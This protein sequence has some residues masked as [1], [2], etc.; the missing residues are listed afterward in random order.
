MGRPSIY[1]DEV[2][3]EV[4]RRLSDGETL[5]QICADDH[6]PARPTVL[7]WVKNDLN[8]FSDRYARA[9]AALIEFWAD[10]IVDIC[11]TTTLGVETTTKEDGAIET[12]EGDM[13]GHRKLQIDTRKWLLSK[14]RPDKYGDKIEIAGDPEKPLIPTVNVTIGSAASKSAPACEAG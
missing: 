1:S 4:C 8:G 14:L 3:D 12:R 2:A 7:L 13:L 6:L 11:D 9:R 10:Q 5:N